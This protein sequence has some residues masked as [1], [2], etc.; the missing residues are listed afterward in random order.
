MD[1]S[2]II[3]VIDLRD[4]LS[5]DQNARQRCIRAI[6]LGFHEV[7]FISIIHHGIP[8]KF[9]SD[10]YAKAEE[11]FLLPQPVKTRY[12]NPLPG[13][14]RGF[15]SMGREHVKNM[16]TPDLKEFWHV[17]RETLED[18]SSQKLYPQNPWPSEVAGFKETMLDLYDRLEMVACHILEAAAIHLGLA[19]LSMCSSITDG[20]TVLRLAHYPPVPEGTDVSTFRSAP[21]E[22]IDFITL[23]CEATGDG[24]EIL[25]RENRWV[26]VRNLPGQIIVNAGD[27]LQNLT[28]GYYRS[29]THRVTNNNMDRSRRLSMPFFVHP[30]AEIDLAPIPEALAL[31]D[32]MTRFEGISAGAYF[33]RRLDEIGFG[34]P[35]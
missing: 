17:G 29:T 33:Q 27:M 16:K 14:P 8:A 35:R 25:T 18:G 3:P 9:I 15:S 12:E 6:G 19:P 30:R 21:H 28:N 13:D 10:A 24:L 26:P 5:S 22:D 31:T 32:N 4:F 2:N 23:L 20:N 11:F 1:I 7:G 34:K